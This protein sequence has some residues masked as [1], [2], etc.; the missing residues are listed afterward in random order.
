MT[1]KHLQI[2]AAALLLLAVILGAVAWK[3]AHRPPAPAAAQQNENG[4]TLYPVVVTVKPLEAGKP[5]TADQVAVESLPINPADAFADAGK[6]VGREPITPIGTGVP[7][8]G[9]QLSSGLALQVAPGQRAVAITVDEVVGVGNRVMPGDYVDVFLVLR[10][11]GQEI[12]DSKARLLLPH[13]RVL[14]FGPLAIN[15][16]PQTQPE[17]GANTVTRRVD[18]AKTAV[19]AVPVESVSQLAIAHQSGR[20]LLALR[21]PSD[22]AEPTVRPQDAQALAV[23]SR[24]PLDAAQAGAS[25]VSVTGGARRP[26]ALL[27]AL[28]AVATT[29]LAVRSAATATGVEI[30]RA[31]KREEQHD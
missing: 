28:P 27:S 25:L 9:S 13:L 6:V 24:N 21:N 15:E 12:D 19:L 1:S 5:I 14:A 31:G 2:F 7:L 20:L 23:V 22:D 3:S 30:I 18:Q 29:H 10:K 16:G 11:D 26:M 8:I 4:K 17:S